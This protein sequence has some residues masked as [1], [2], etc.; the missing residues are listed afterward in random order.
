M[1]SNADRVIA[2]TRWRIE[3]TSPTHQRPRKPFRW[4]DLAGVDAENY[5]ALRLFQVLW[6][7]EE[8]DEDS[9]TD[10][11]ERRAVHKIL[12]EVAYA[13]DYG[14]ELRQEIMLQ[15]RHDL[16]KT[17]RDPRL[18]AGTSASD[19]TGE[20]G[21]QA[22]RVTAARREFD[23]DANMAI[24]RIECDCEIWETE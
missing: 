8:D 23:D 1:G 15:D 5:P 21:L 17:L 6:L 18:F 14:L 13:D 3:S 24:L 20:T 7:E 4:M 10:L 9:V 19:P 12:I 16:I 2:N 11:V 22:R